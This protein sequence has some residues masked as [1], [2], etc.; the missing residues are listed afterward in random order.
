MTLF[1][2]AGLAATLADLVLPRQCAGCSRPGAAVCPGCGSALAGPAFAADAG[3]LA[4][5]GGM[6]STCYAVAT[7]GGPVREI[8]LGY[9]ERDRRDAGA[10][11]A[12]GLAV[13]VAAVLASDWALAA[14]RASGPDAAVRGSRPA[15]GPVLAVPVPSSSSASRARGFDHVRRLATGAARD[16]RRGGHDIEVAPLLRVARSVADQAGLGAAG[17]AENL[18]GA[19]RCRVPIELA[20]RRWRI[21]VV[22]VDDVVTTGATAAEAVRALSA[23]GFDVLGCAVVAATPVRIG[24]IWAPKGHSLANTSQQGVHL[25]ATGVPEG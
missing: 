22:V 20:P 21:P 7:Y 3:V 2:F 8:L 10:A 23:A 24:R 17:R 18:S 4:N 16:L 19:F 1:A 12:M 9:K 5:A 25:P 14:D 15:V 6:V 13:S 11:L